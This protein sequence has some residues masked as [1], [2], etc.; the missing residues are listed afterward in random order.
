MNTL[1]VL[2]KEFCEINE[3]PPLSFLKK[4]V[5]SYWLMIVTLFTLVQQNKTILFYRWLLVGSKKR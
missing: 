1:Q 5:A 4:I 2:L 3:L